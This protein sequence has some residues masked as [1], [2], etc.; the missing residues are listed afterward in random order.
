[1]GRLEK[2]DLE[3]LES[4]ENAACID[5]A[6]LVASKK[7]HEESRRARDGSPSCGV[8]ST[9][10]ARHRFANVRAAA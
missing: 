3:T 6:P 10:L 7:I 2:L 1:M 5:T 9:V 8:W 4:N